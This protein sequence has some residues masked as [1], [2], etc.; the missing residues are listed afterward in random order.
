M[1]ATVRSSGRRRA[2]AGVL[3][4][5]GAALSFAVL[6]QVQQPVRVP[7]FRY[8]APA[9]APAPK[10]GEPC[11]GCGVIRA[12][13]EVQSQRP[14]PV[15]KPLQGDTMDRGPGSSVLVGA[16]VALPTGEGS[17]GGQPFVGGVGTPEMRSRFTETAYEIVVRLD[18]GAFTRVQRR[19]GASFR[20]GDRVRVRGVQMELLA[21]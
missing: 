7:D 16:V 3:L 2:P 10:A 15:P 6:A 18:N 8:H 19:D 11:D 13:R 4:A 1:I 9:A 17:A 14:I 5:A 12:I 20:V 21:P